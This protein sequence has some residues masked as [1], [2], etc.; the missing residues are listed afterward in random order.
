MMRFVEWPLAL[1]AIP[2]LLLL[3]VLAFQTERRSR[4]KRLAKLGS[5]PMLMR[6]APFGTRLGWWRALRI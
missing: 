2:V 1:L 6:L 5:F 4:A 3:S